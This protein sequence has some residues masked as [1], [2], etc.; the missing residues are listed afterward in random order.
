MRLLLQNMLVEKILHLMVYEIFFSFYSVNVY[1]MNLNL[2]IRVHRMNNEGTR[3][4]VGIVS[5]YF[6]IVFRI[7]CDSVNS[8][9]GHKFRRFL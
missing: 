4:N 8:N 3:K 1:A 7:F 5:I 9:C 6:K 2:I